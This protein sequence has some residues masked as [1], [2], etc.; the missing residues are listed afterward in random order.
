MITLLRSLEMITL[1]ENLL[2]YQIKFLGDTWTEGCSAASAL[3]LAIIHGHHHIIKYLIDHGAD[4]NIE[5]VCKFVTNEVR[6]IFDQ[7]SSRT[8]TNPS[9]QDG[10]QSEFNIE[11]IV[12]PSSSGKK[13]NLEKSLDSNC[14]SSAS[15]PKTKSRKTQTLDK[16][17]TNETSPVQV[18]DNQENPSESTYSEQIRSVVQPLLESFLK[19][20]FSYQTKLICLSAIEAIIAKDLGACDFIAKKE[21]FEEISKIVEDIVSEE[22]D[23]VNC[24]LVLIAKILAKIEHRNAEGKKLVGGM[25]M[26][27]SAF[28]KLRTEMKKV[29]I[30]SNPGDFA[31]DSD[32]GINVKNEVSDIF[33][34]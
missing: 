10:K 4:Q 23:K 20:N 1:F 9:S 7:I 24:D 8:D 14:V 17:I 30:M 28:D 25:K 33:L 21:F 12:S 31:F 11:E 32:Q 19:E 16:N 6:E 34:E 5:N 3:H 13:R 22:S 18:Q 26:S 29:E 27:F 15:E 2:D